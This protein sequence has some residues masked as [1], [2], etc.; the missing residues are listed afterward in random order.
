[1]SRRDRILA[2]IEEL[3]G[4]VSEFGRRL[5]SLRAEVAELDEFEVVGSTVSEAEFYSEKKDIS[6]RAYSGTPPTGALAAS[7][8]GEPTELERQEAAI[9]TG[10]FFAG[11]LS[12]R[13]RGNSG[14]SRIHLQNHIYVLVRTISGAEH[15]DPVLVFRAFSKLKPYVSNSAGDFG[16]SIFAGFNAEWEARLA[17]REAGLSWPSASQ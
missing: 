12:G 3:Q 13:P 2:E 17:V 11:C 16:N 5:A 15:I 7:R 4:Q 14:R 9:A 6:S 10:H 8:P 1:M